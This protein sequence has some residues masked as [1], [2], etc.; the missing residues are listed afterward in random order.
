MRAKA[1]LV[2]ALLAIAPLDQALSWGASGHSIIAEI[3]QRRLHPRVLTQIEDLLGGNVSLASIA[4]WA[5][6]VVLERPGTI[7]WHFVNIPYEANDYQ[8]DRDCK[9]SPKGDCVINAISRSMTVLRDRSATKERRTEALKF[10]IHYVGD[11]HQP[12]HAIN[13]NDEGGNK[14]AVTFFGAPMSLHAVWDFGLIEKRTYDWGQYVTVLESHWLRGK[15]IRVLQRGTPVDWALQAH[16]AAVNVAYVV[17]DDLQL[18]E[19]Y[20]LRSIPIVDQQLAL[21]G[22]RLARLLNEAFGHP[23]YVGSDRCHTGVCP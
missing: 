16:A 20:Y 11:V 17:P 2:A 18:G 23:G 5:D 19:A 3:A 12:L 13:R 7:G 14:I 9:P 10:L 6:D 15:D 21:A 4:S 8:P 1:I 22:I